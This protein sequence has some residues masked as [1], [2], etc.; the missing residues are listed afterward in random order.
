MKGSAYTYIYLY[1]HFRL[2]EQKKSG[3]K[4]KIQ[5]FTGSS[6]PCNKIIARAGLMRISFKKEQRKTKIQLRCWKNEKTKH[7]VDTPLCAEY[8]IKFCIK[9]M[10]IRIILSPAFE[11]E[12]RDVKCY[13][14]DV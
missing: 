10:S 14:L 3:R 13:V 9:N 5:K 2:K 12:K 1:V 7:E 11:V 4:R 6:Q 8:L